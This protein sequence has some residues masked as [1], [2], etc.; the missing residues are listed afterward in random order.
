MR[1]AAGKRK[2]PLA[3]A[4]GRPSLIDCRTP[5]ARREGNLAGLAPAP[6][7]QCH[8]PLS[9]SR[10]A[11]SELVKRFVGTAPSYVPESA[12]VKVSSSFVQADVVEHA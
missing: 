6:P 5:V 12:S 1:D 4:P 11:S 7:H 3:Q 8:V 9:I 10:C 2:W